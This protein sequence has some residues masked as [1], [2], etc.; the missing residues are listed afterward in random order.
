MPL[1][2]TNRTI[3]EFNIKT[4]WEEITWK[5][6][7]QLEQMLNADIPAAYKTVNIIA[8][9]TGQSVET[10]ERLPM[11]QFQK[12]I[13][14]TE[15]LYTDAETRAVQMR[16]TI[17]ERVYNLR[18]DL[19][20]ITTSQYIDYSAYM[21][22]EPKDIVKLT[23]AFLVPD[24]HDYNDGYDME[25]VQSDINDMCWL[26]VRAIAFFFRIQLAAFILILKSYLIPTMEKTKATKDQ[27][28]EWEVHCDSMAYSL[29]YAESATKQTHALIQSLDGQ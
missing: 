6:Y 11:S 12:L 26:D 24:G 22:E 14:H 19:T 4:T 3:M 13:P 8:L 2:I 1:K 16:Y 15:F 29:L 7:E 9:L 17:N 28:T 5:E 27:I 20:Q 25:L 23:S 10:I 18:A 21:Q